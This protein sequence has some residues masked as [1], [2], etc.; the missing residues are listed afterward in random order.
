MDETAGRSPSEWIVLGRTASDLGSLT[1]DP[2]WAPL[3]DV[4]PIL[5]TDDYSDIVSVLRW[6]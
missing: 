2:A 3:D 1:S 4:D 5:W 6:R